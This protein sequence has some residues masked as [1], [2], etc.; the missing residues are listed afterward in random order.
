MNVPQWLEEGETVVVDAT[1]TFERDRTT[2]VGRLFLTT[3]RIVFVKSRLVGRERP[4][5][6]H[7]YD[8]VTGAELTG[9]PKRLVLEV[10]G[11]SFAYRLSASAGRRLLDAIAER[12]GVRA[13]EGGEQ[14]PG[15]AGEL[16][17][18]ADLHA[19]GALTDDEFAA[20]KRRI[21][22]TD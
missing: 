17:R 1:A 22:N 11:E 8:A 5:L 9:R 12:A 6:V 16:Q 21:L 10:G 4:T 3:E 15:L 20:A 2:A 19:S 18:V 7:L 13:D 14:P